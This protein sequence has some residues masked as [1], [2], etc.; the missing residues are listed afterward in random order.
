MIW[1]YDCLA[2]AAI[3]DRAAEFHYQMHFYAVSTPR[4]NI[5]DRPGTR[6][7]IIFSL[8]SFSSVKSCSVKF[9]SSYQAL[10]TQAPPSGELLRSLTCAMPLAKE[11]LNT[12]RSLL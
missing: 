5:Q 10:R 9:Q 4:L 3:L 7:I 12:E 8:L 6:K 11:L 1:L 2:R